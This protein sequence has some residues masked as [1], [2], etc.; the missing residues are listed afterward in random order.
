MQKGH[1]WMNNVCIWAILLEICGSNWSVN[2]YK[3]VAVGSK[4]TSCDYKP[5]GYPTNLIPHV[6]CDPTVATR[7]LAPRPPIG[8]AAMTPGEEFTGKRHV[9]LDSLWWRGR[10]TVWHQTICDLAVRADLFYALAR[11]FAMAQRVFFLVKDS[12]TRPWERSHQLEEFQGV[13]WDWQATRDIFG[14]VESKR[15]ACGRP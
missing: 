7:L 8:G 13:P 1:G 6:G 2:R 5:K 4:I 11:R 12:R 14:R 10:S 9:C 3:V 15:D